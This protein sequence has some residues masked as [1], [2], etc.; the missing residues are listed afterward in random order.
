[1]KDLIESLTILAKYLDETYAPTHCEHDIL[2]VPGVTK[3]E[4][5]EEDAKKLDDLGWHYDTE[6]DC[7]ASFR[8]GSC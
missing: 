3:E 8:F 1:M 6:Y 7:W 5:S 4:V 2:M